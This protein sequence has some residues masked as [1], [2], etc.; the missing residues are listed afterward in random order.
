MSQIDF[1]KELISW[2]RKE[3]YALLDVNVFPRP[4]ASPLPVR[5]PVII[6]SLDP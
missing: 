4:Y 2:V 3:N 6:Y 5:V 1:S